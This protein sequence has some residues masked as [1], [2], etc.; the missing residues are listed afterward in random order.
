VG[1]PVTVEF[2]HIGEVLPDDANWMPMSGGPNTWNA[3]PNL[4]L[5]P[6][7]ANQNGRLFIRAIDATQECLVSSFAV[8]LLSSGTGLLR[9]QTDPAV[10]TT[11]YLDGIPRDDWALNWVKLPEGPYTL[12]FSDVYAYD[13]PASVTV[14]Y[15]PGTTGNIQSLAD[16]IMIY[17]NTVTEVIANFAPQG[18]L[19]VQTSPALPA[20]I[21]LDGH[22]MDDWS[23]WTNI[24]PG[25]YDIS[26]QDVDGYDT[27]AP[28]LAVVVTAGVLTEIT[29]TYTPNGAATYPP[30]AH[31]LLRVQTSPAVPS[32]IFLDGLQR[33]D[34]ALNWVQLTPG[35]YMLSF[36]DVYAYDTPTSVTV[37]YYPGTTGNIQSLADPIMIYD[38]VVTEVIVNF[39]QMGNLR[40]E[41]TPATEATIFLDGHPMDDWAFWLNI[42]PGD[43]TVSFQPVSGLAT[44]PPI[45]VTVLAGATTHVIGDYL[46]GESLTNP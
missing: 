8:D 12:S 36:S 44:P 18:Y 40:V 26:F 25:S 23:F 22:P 28:Q 9:V 24:T 31:G 17:D 1:N 19:R 7:T 2:D 45:D 3:T 34:W 16:P 30:V 4:V 33:D 37:N 41:T 29:G 21:F 20:T 27:P 5:P 46:N 32:T 42:L 35:P 11:I 39:A 38:G 10:P 6:L 43:Y 13:T 14:N 15:Y